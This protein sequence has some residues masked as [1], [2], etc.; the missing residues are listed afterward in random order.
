MNN[1]IEFLLKSPFYTFKVDNFLD[2]KLYKDLQ[3]NFPTLDIY[4][5]EDGKNGKFFLDSKSENYQNYLKKNL[6]MRNLDNFVNDKCFF[7]FFSKKLYF[8]FLKSQKNNMFRFIKY[9]RP[10]KKYFGEKKFTDL[11]FSMVSV[12]IQYSIML[13]GG[14]IVPHVDSI[15][16]FLSLMIY[17]PD[18]NGKSLND[19]EKIKEKE[20]GTQFW[21]SNEKNYINQHIDDKKNF[22]LNAKRIYK[23]PF[24]EN[25]LYGFIRNDQSWHS[26]DSINVNENYTRKSININFFYRN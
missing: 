1:K 8:Y 17:F 19:N 12:N 13:N 23:S 5:F 7:N 10:T 15:R 3:N 21:Y 25:N 14:L 24:I 2:Q 11:F 26:V 9:L 4:E 18:I 16:K 22:E 6:A 20:C